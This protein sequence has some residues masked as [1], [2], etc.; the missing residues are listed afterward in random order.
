M[1]HKP[2]KYGVKCTRFLDGEPCLFGH[3]HTLEETKHAL[4]AHLKALQD[5]KRIEELRGRVKEATICLP[6]P[7]KPVNP[8][9]KTALCDKFQQTGECPYGNACDFAHGDHE[10]LPKP[11]QSVKPVKPV[12]PL[13]KTALCDKFQQTGECPYGDACDFAHGDHELLPMPEQSVKPVKPVNPLRKTVLCDKFQQTG[14]CPYGDACDF[15]H[16]DHEL[17]PMPERKTIQCKFNLM[18][19]CRNYNCNFH[20]DKPLV[21][22]YRPRPRALE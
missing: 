5:K 13:R 1:S 2:C 19:G 9:R 21:A 17:L 12:N 4:E 10:L 3:K 11:E 16:G 18:R 22:R 6:K 8:L 7:V 15:A 20:H 14:E